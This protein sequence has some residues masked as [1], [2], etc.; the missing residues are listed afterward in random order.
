M[1][2]VMHSLRICLGNLIRELHSGGLGGLFGIEKTKELV[3]EKYY[4]KGLEMDAENWIN[5]CRIC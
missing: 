1:S 2:L 3:E 5:H 4:W